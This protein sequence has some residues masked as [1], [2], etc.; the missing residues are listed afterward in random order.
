MAAVVWYVIS[1]ASLATQEF[2][3]VDKN[4]E[5]SD[6]P[7]KR[8]LT[9]LVN[10][11]LVCSCWSLMAA[12]GRCDNSRIFAF[13]AGHSVAKR[14]EH[15]FQGSR[16]LDE[17]R[18]VAISG[19]QMSIIEHLLD[20]A[21]IPAGDLPDVALAQARNSLFDWIVCGRAGIGEPLAKIL[22]EMARRE[23]GSEVASVLGMG[24][25]PARMAAL[26]N[27]TTSHALDYDD[28]HFA[29]IGHLSVG[30]YPA[31]LAAGEEV[32]ASALK[33][34]EAFLVGAEV[35]IRVGMVLGA[36]HYNRG[37]HQTATAGA[38]GATVAAGR[39]H[40]LS[41]DQMRNAIGLCATRA[42]GLKSQFGT[43]GKPYNAGIAAAN[44]VE[45]AQL[46]KMGMTGPDDGLLGAQGFVPTHADKPDAASFWATPVSDRF[47]FPD[48]KYKLHACCHGT[49]A[50]IEALMTLRATHE[51]GIGD[52]ERISLKTN[53]RWLSVCDIAEPRTG[54]EVKFSYRVLAG[55]VMSGV[56]TDNDTAY[57]D[58]RAVDAELRAFA[59]RVEVTGDNDLT[60]QMAVGEVTLHNGTVLGFS[61]D[62]SKSIA[63][64]VISASLRR[65]ASSLLGGEAD[66]IATL[67]ADLDGQ[68]ARAIG[69]VLAG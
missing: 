51:I 31:A 50:M 36:G 45:C 3:S 19:E 35:A 68:S 30:I 42:S 41:R 32:D 15:W 61:H 64:D 4:V 26:V 21:E 63:P 66:T 20:L 7:V 69:A 28:T 1:G 49:H 16:S 34:V 53:P 39:L 55:M 44:G 57:S 46:A 29:H 38:F 59:R 9:A 27:G 6:Q 62:L 25:V 14:F 33:V 43:M 17:D 48:I 47:L 2:V 23:G 12:I 58:E 24:R 65:K 37:F 56:Q 52:V 18:D 11:K 40:G 67:V 10:T 54:L 60:D 8:L 13:R 5:F 22:R